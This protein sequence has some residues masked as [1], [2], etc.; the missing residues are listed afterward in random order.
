MRERSETATSVALPARAENS[1]RHKR[2]QTEPKA[3][4]TPLE[5]LEWPIRWRFVPDH[6]SSFFM[7]VALVAGRR[8][9]FREG[10]HSW[11]PIQPRRLG[12]DAP[13][14]S[15]ETL[16][17]KPHEVRSAS[18]G[19]GARAV[20]SSTPAM[21]GSSRFPGGM[22]GLRPDTLSEGDLR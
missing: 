19:W 14:R 11:G 13:R 6:K 22:S 2:H 3:L 10:S 18:T 5:P 1:K 12:T 9:V 21:A 4:S 20:A 8:G 15:D 7:A 17:E 16:R